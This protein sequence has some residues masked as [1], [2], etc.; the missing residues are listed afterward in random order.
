[1]ISWR[2]K[3]RIF[4]WHYVHAENTATEIIRRVRRTRDGDRYIVYF[5]HH[6]VFIDR[7]DHYWKITELTGDRPELHLTAQVIDFPDRRA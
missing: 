1:M 2:L 5:D 7:P 4:G 3:H 6:V